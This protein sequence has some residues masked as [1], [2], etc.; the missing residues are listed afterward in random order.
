MESHGRS[1]HIQVTQSTYEM[2]KHKYCFEPRGVVSV[3]GLGQI[4]TYWLLG[5]KE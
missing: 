5:V 2:A 3:K 4:Q 1:D